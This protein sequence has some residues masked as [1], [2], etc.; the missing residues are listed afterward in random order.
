M[1][2]HLLL[3]THGWELFEVAIRKG[4]ELAKAIQAKVTGFYVIPQFHIFT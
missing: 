1:F 3:P 4:I 2:N